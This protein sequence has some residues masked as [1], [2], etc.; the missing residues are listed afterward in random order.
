MTKVVGLSTVLALSNAASW[1]HTEK[2]QQDP[3]KWQD[4]CQTGESQTPIALYTS[5]TESD[6]ADPLNAFAAYGQYSGKQH[7]GLVQKGSGTHGFKFTFDE[8]LILGNGYACSQWHC[9]FKSEHT[10]DDE[11]R[12]WFLNYDQ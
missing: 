11:Y 9:H 7:S 5:D 1:S 6:E 2:D 3:T 10:I 4:A 12:V 8:Q